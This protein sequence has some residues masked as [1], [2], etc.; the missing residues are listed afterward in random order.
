MII[1]AATENFTSL[2]RHLQRFSRGA[3]GARIGV[4]A[5]VSY[6]AMNVELT[7][8]ADAYEAIVSPA[9]SAMVADTDTESPDFAAILLR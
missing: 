9:A 1:C 2:P 3:T 6:A 5:Q 7:V 4:G 8:G